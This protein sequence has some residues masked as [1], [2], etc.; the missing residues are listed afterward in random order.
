[1]LER[2]YLVFPRREP[3]WKVFK[4]EKFSK[5]INVERI[6]E[7]EKVTPKMKVFLGLEKIWVPVSQDL[8]YDKELAEARDEQV[9]AVTPQHFLQLM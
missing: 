5:A 4:M 6:S 3:C 1:M 9:K 8:G 2:Y 7:E